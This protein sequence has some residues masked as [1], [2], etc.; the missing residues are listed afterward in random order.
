MILSI[1]IIY[2]IILLLAYSNAN[3][4]WN[5]YTI[6]TDIVLI[7]MSFFI[8]KKKENN[9]ILKNNYLKHSNIF[10]LGY[11]IVFYQVYVDYILGNTNDSLPFYWEDYSIVTKILLLSGIGI[12]SFL[13]GYNS[14]NKSVK[15]IKIKKIF[16]NP[17][18]LNLLSIISLIFIVVFINPQYLNGNYG[19]VEMGVVSQ[20]FDFFFN[21]LITSSFIITIINI[22]GSNAKEI[23]LIQYFK[24]HGIS[25]I[26]PILLYLILI[27][28]SGDRGPLIYI[29]VLVISGFFAINKRKL[30]LI[31]FIMI[32]FIGT[33]LITL[34]G[35]VRSM[36]K[37][38]ALVNRVMTYEKNTKYDS[39]SPY[40]LELGSSI[41]T[42][43]RVVSYVPSQHNF[44]YGTFHLNLLISSIPT[45]GG[46]YNSMFNIPEKYSNSASFTTWIAQGDNP[47]SGDGTTCLSDLYCDFGIPG[48]ILGM[49]L[50]GYFLRKMEIHMYSGIG[51]SLFFTIA[52]FIY[53][54]KNIYIPRASI[55][56]ELRNVV[57]VYIIVSIYYKLMHRK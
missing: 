15:E 52:S 17:I 16:T 1:R 21:L 38:K 44:F 3:K 30:K 48:I 6:L 18:Y 43:N 20:Y 41:R 49:F 22:K 29:S 13:I 9:E 7:L 46:I 10:I 14:F 19:S 28:I 57:M 31:S 5:S 24:I 33:F 26:I 34:L 45:A 47:T 4:N 8:F 56:F 11:I 50:F 37:D 51:S 36:D 23:N 54:S 40:T 42:F 2:I 25:F 35:I 53:L 12:T 32:L 27:L 55:I 39:F